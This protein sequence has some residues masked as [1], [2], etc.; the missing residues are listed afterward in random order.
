MSSF[1]FAFQVKYRLFQNIY[2]LVYLISS[3]LF[4]KTAMQEQK[5]ATEESL[6]SANRAPCETENQPF[7][8]MKYN[9]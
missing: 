1:S 3:N 4:G 8:G 9:R 2:L 6:C 7:Y 5:Y